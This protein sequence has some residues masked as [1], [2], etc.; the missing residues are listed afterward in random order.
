MWDSENWQDLHRADANSRMRVREKKVI[1][2]A[3]S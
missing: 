3:V 1:I 2:I